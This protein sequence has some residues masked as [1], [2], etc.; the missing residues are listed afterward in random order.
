MAPCYLREYWQ[1][2]ALACVAVLSAGERESGSTPVGIFAAGASK[3]FSAVGVPAHL[4]VD[5][6]ACNQYLFFSLLWIPVPV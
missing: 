6:H 4:G 2:F 3:F 1:F 5:C